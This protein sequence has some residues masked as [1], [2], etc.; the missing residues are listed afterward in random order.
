VLS[1]A[2]DRLED[3]AGVLMFVVI[4]ESTERDLLITNE[5]H[6]DCANSGDLDQPLSCIIGELLR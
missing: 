2:F 5:R 3:G 1:E 4:D 6:T